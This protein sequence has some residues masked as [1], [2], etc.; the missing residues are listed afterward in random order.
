LVEIERASFYLSSEGVMIRQ[1]AVFR[2]IL[3][4]HLVFAAVVLEA[5]PTRLGETVAVRSEILGQLRTL[6]VSLPASYYQSDRSY[7]VLYLLDGNWHFPVV[8]SQVRYLS[9]C[10]ASDIIAPE[11]IVVGIENVDRDHDLTPTY[12]PDYKGMEFPTS[13]GASDFLK[14]LTRELVPFIDD[15]YRTVDH[16]ILGG[17]SFGGLFTIYS[18]MES[19]GYFNG[20]LGI[21]P[22]VW[23][24]EESLLSRT[25]PRGLERPSRLVMTIGAEEEGG[26]NHNGWKNLG[27]RLEQVPVEGLDVTLI[28]IEGAGHNQSLPL[29]YYRAIRAFYSDWLAPDEVIEAGRERIDQYYEALSVQYGYV[30]P[31]PESVLTNLGIGH[32]R[33]DRFDDA[34]VAF[35]EIIGLYPE[36]SYAHFLLGRVWQKRGATEAARDEYLRAIQ[37]EMAQRPPDGLDLRYFRSSLAEVET[38]ENSVE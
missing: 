34:Q 31:I 18:L 20:Y 26:W 32:L 7:P 15:T 29:A 17:W 1:V 24:E 2:W 35:E 19:P 14:F 5:Q 11:L 38:A 21:S 22:S 37:I 36:S 33:A 9:E 28:E 4:A 27:E 23:W 16:R 25:L 13:G 12:V 8:A 10:S 6:Y 3:A 30:V